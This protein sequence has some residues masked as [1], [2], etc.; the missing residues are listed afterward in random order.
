MRISKDGS[1]FVH[2][3]QK[4]SRD[5]NVRMVSQ[6]G[7]EEGGINGCVDVPLIIT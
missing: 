2:V 6:T 1:N 7:S 5:T 3:V 4:K